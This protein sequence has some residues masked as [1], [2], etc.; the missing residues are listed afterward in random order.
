MTFLG[1]VLSVLKRTVSFVRLVHDP[2]RLDLV[3][4][5]ADDAGTTGPIVEVVAKDPVGA[6]ALVERHRLGCPQFDALDELPPG[7]LGR[8]F[9]DHMRSNGLDPSALP[10]SDANDPL[11]FVIAHLYETHDIW[12]VVTGFGV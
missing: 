4:E 3:F 1:N 2:S 9:A 7:T 10:S 8:V 11:E 6:Q 5:L 12:H